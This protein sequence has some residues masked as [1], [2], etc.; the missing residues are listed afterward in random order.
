MLVPHL[1]SSV[2]VCQCLHLVKDSPVLSSAFLLVCDPFSYH[3]L[4][5]RLIH[6]ET[7]T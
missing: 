4:S 2:A 1:V 5:Q 3:K 6:G 7:V